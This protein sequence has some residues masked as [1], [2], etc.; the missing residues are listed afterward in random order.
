MDMEIMIGSTRVPEWI[1]LAL[2]TATFLIQSVYYI[3]IYLL[4]PLHKTPKKRKRS[5]GV[6]IVICA[7]NEATN[8]EQFLPAVLNQDYPEFEVVVVNDCSTD[9]TEEVLSQLATQYKHLRYTSI[10]S[11]ENFSHGKKLA[12]TVGL[13]SAIFDLV[14]LTDADCY[15]DGNLWLQKMISHLGKDVDI[16]LG[17]G[18]YEKR[19]GLLNALIRYET[20]FTAIQYFS[21]ALRGRPYM[22]VGRN[23]GYQKSLF[24][25]NKGF[26]SHYH[27]A[28][29]DDDLFVNE[30]ANRKNTAVEFGPGSHTISIPKT[31]VGAWIRQKQRHV[32]AGNLYDRG[33]RLLLGMEMISR[34]VFYSTFLILC[35]SSGWLWPVIIL[36]SLFQII[37]TTILKLGMMRLN[38]KYLLLPSFLFD[39]VLPI[40]LGLIWFRNI[41]VSKYQPWS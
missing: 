40:I 11:N 9:A 38:E 26:S 19:K 3:G 29:G 37:R 33:T 30:H 17:Y 6:S 35:I 36:F 22:G 21:F 23:L 16:V 20:V 34:L 12:L 39:P 24:F 31:S 15:P 1:L 32:T 2:Y 13:K 25:K 10:P 27:I 8:L 4:L 5:K 41:F 7:K 28:S 18:K 14:L